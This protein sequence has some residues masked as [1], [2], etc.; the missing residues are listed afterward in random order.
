MNRWRFATKKV[1]LS[2]LTASP[3][4]QYTYQ[5]QLPDDLIY[6]IRTQQ[7]QDYEVYE[8]KLYSNNSSV[9]IDYTYR[10]DESNL[11]PYFVKAFEYMFA[12]EL[13]I[14]VVGNSTREQEY[15]AKFEKQYA[16]AAFLDASQRP[17]DEQQSHAYLDVRN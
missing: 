8:D 14:P 1:E 13:A 15:T 3:E 4:N 10:V 9:S 16:R 5:Y 17:A 2:K 11:P 7:K 6:L 12:S